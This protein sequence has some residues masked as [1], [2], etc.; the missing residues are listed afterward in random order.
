MD[1]LIER[2]LDIKYLSIVKAN[3]NNKQVVE[4]SNQFLEKFDKKIFLRKIN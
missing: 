2:I 3:R 4:I 1:I